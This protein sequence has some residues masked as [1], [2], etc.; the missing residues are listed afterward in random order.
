[1]TLG[2]PEITPL[3]IDRPAGNVGVISQVA[4]A[5]PVLVATIS[6]IVEFLTKV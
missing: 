3:L 2:V 6:V 5:P 4:T 1:M